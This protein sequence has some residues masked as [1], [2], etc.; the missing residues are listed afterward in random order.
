MSD[1]TKN[2]TWTSDRGADSDPANL[3]TEFDELATVSA[4]KADLASPTFSGTPT[5]P[6]GTVATTQSASD[7]TTKLATT[8]YADT[9]DGLLTTLKANLASPTLTGVPA[10]PTAA[11][12]TDTTQIATTAFVNASANS[13]VAQNHLTTVGATQYTNDVG[14]DKHVNLVVFAGG[15]VL[16]SI[17]IFIAGNQVS[18]AQATANIS[19]CISFTI[20]AGMTYGWTLTG[21]G[22]VVAQAYEVY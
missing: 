7:G 11:T 20:P 4:T 9:A 19:N 18:Y 6:T 10:A 13:T 12:G 14:K 16:S 2:R 5:L 3:D 21:V 15:G 22:A 1:Y 8:L 17:I